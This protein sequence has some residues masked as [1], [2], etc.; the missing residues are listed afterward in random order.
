MIRRAKLADL[1]QI[2]N[3]SDASAS[4]AH[5][6]VEVYAS[7]LRGEGQAR[8]VLVAENPSQLSIGMLVALCQTEDWELENIVVSA[9]ERQKGIGRKLMDALIAEAIAG[10]AEKILLE[11][12]ASNLAAIRLYQSCGFEIWSTRKS[13]YSNP[14]EDAVVMTKK[15]ENRHSKTVE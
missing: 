15:M 1:E 11:V 2:V 10:G 9:S 12:R 6:P 13:Y 7:M 8:V 14:L 5:W 3:L 4:A